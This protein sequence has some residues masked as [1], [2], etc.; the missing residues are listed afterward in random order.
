MSRITF[1]H[2]ANLG[3]PVQNQ[4][5]LCWFAS[6]HCTVE[7][8]TDLAALQTRLESEPNLL[9]YLPVACLDRLR[10]RSQIQGVASATVGSSGLSTT[11][12]VLIVK[13][14]RDLN[15]LPDLNGATYAR[16]N[17][18]CTS[19]QLAPALLLHQ[20][21]LRYPQLF[22]QVLEVAVQPGQ[23]QHQIDQVLDGHADATMVDEATW[24]ASPQN[25][26]HTQVLGRVD[27][28]P[29][30]VVLSNAVDEPALVAAFKQQLLSFRRD[31]AAM[32]SGF[33]AYP[34]ASLHAFLDGL[35]RCT[36]AGPG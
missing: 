26:E 11:T 21:G 19:S 15:T 9:A 25:I 22:A 1:L 12:S 4:Q 14:G 18:F 33:V 35:D 3:F 24:L 10:A 16:I 5:W 31:P 17:A 32:F 27:G 36:S 2:D 13:R 7:G 34:E 8:T 23:W 6:H 29:C 20:H 28:L 30:P